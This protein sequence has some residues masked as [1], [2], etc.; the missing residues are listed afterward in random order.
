MSNLFKNPFNTINLACI[1]SPRS[2]FALLPGEVMRTQGR[3]TSSW[4]KGNVIFLREGLSD[5]SITEP[6]LGGCALNVFRPE[7]AM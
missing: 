6:G 1:M 5:I 2:I 3:P 7:F 4:A